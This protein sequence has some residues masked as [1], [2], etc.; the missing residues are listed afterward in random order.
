MFAKPNG[1]YPCALTFAYCILLL[2]CAK[3]A[4]ATD[5]VNWEEAPIRYSETEPKRN[6][7][8]RLQ[9][10]LDQ[11]SIRLEHSGE[12]GYLKSVLDHLKIPISSQ[13]LVFSKTSLQDNKISPEKPRAIYFND[14]T[15]VG[16]VRDGVIEVAAAD[17][18]LGMAFYT[19]DPDSV[20]H[21]KFVRQA[22]RCLSCHGAARTSGVPGLLVRSVYPNPKGEP[23]VKA[24]SFLSNHRSPLTQRWGGWYVTGFHGEQQHIGNYRLS[25][26]KKPK[27]F[28]NAAGMNLKSLEAYIDFKP[29]LS[30]HSDIVALMVLEHQIEA[31]NLL[32]QANFV[33][34]HALW[35]RDHSIAMGNDR[36][37][38]EH[39]A[40]ER[41]RKAVLPLAHYLLFSREAKLTEPVVGTS[42]FQLDFE[43][44]V[45]DDAGRSARQFDL[46][47]RML[48]VRLSYLIYSQTFAEQPQV[49]RRALASELLAATEETYH[50]AK[51]V[52]LNAEDRQAIRELLQKSPPAWF[53]F[54][55]VRDSKE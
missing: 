51:Q 6:A 54:D 53:D 25:Q 32:T 49:L 19:L 46:Q 16:Y 40:G 2:V 10:K 52:E 7:I 30:N 20:E 42:R 18:D 15:H 55:G 36:P 4:V 21:P 5:K 50:E 31:Y 17:A 44:L 14:E 23:V 9:L 26:D 38:A 45:T 13:V 1:I 11:S 48:K 28:D 24:G 41:I 22:N 35:E 43:A 27:V 12:Q 37:Q 33:S 3:Y 39:A 34:Q 47:T 8:A 29:Y